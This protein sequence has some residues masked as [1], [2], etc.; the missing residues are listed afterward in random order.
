MLRAVSAAG[1]EDGK[2]VH[3]YN[4]YV[5]R[6]DPSDALDFGTQGITFFAR[7]PM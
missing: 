7:K 3:K 4:S 1:F 2:I 5:D 6:P